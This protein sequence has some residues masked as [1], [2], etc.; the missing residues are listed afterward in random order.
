M[1]RFF[2]TYLLT[3]ILVLS[4]QAILTQ[5]AIAQFAS[6]P[7]PPPEINETPASR[8]PSEGGAPI[9]DGA[10]IL[11]TLVVGYG[12]HSYKSYKKNQHTTNQGPGNS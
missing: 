2:R 9:G 4:S 7:L 11:I 6:P 5:D 1:K 8:G 12:I 10:W 3:L